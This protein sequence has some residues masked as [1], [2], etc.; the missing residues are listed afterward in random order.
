VG[1]RYLVVIY[2]ELSAADGFVIT[3]YFLRRI[4]RRNIKWRRR[5]RK[6]KGRRLAEPW[7]WP[8]SW[9]NSPRRSSGSITMPKPTYVLYISL[10][11]PQ[12]A[13]ETIDVEEEGVLLHYRGGELVGITV[14]EASKRGPRNR[15]KRGR[16]N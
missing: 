3:A 8:A 9:A 12:K 10:K 4:K 6:H 13:T 2:K 11:R 16:P 7:R 14:L 15:H 5:R 1:N